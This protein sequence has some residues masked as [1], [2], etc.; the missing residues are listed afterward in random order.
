MMEQAFHSLTTRGY[1]AKEAVDRLRTVRPFE[2]FPP[3]CKPSLNQTIMPDPA[4]VFANARNL[5][6]DFLRE[7]ITHAG[8]DRR[9][10]D[11][12]RTS[13]DAL[14]GRCLDRRGDAHR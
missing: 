11:E 9:N 4:A 6:V 1:G 2:L 8:D 5:A 10:R 7:K 13:D 3:S 12:S 14:R